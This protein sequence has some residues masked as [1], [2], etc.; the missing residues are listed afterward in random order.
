MNAMNVEGLEVAKSLDLN[1]QVLKVLESFEFDMS[2][3]LAPD[4]KSSNSTK[5]F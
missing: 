4:T 2:L 3:Q 5:T 1:L